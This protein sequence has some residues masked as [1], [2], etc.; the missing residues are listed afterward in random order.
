MVGRLWQLG[1]DYLKAQA[2]IVLVVIA[3]C[4]TGLWLMGNPYALLAGI[5]IGLLDALPFIGTG[6][7]LLPWALIQVF[8]K[9]FFKAAACATLFLVANTAREVLEPKLLGKKLG[10]YPIVIA[11]AV[12]GGMYLYGA[13][14]VVLG[15]LT[16]LIVAEWAKELN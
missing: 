12:Y 3:L 8:R 6:T 5:L 2:V 1:G 7:I 4:V 15:P 13:A 10:V 14:G 16:L 9:E 11:A